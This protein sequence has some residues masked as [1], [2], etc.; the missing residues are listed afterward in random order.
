MLDG[1]ASREQSATPTGLLGP[2]RA[3]PGS[4]H[5]LQAS[6]AALVTTEHSIAATNRPQQA[7]NIMMNQRR[8]RAVVQHTVVPAMA[9]M[10]CSNSAVPHNTM[11][12]QRGI[13]YTG[14]FSH[15]QP[16]ARA[17]AGIVINKWHSFSG[18]QSHRLL[19]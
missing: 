10:P 4:D 16:A 7:L 18:L 15:R 1:D 17:A 5:Q 14:E 8:C 12:L 9:R 3:L 6:T 2:C 11:P 19:C 13:N